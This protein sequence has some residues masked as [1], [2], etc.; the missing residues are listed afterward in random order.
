MHGACRNKTVYKVLNMNIIIA[1][2]HGFTKGELYSATGAV[3]GGLYYEEIC[4]MA[5]VLE[6]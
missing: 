6:C 4:F 5:L 3:L 1:K 2:V